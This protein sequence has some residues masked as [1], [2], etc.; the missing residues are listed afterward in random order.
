[1]KK[2][3]LATFILATCASSGAFAQCNGNVYAMNAGRGHVGFLIDLQ[4][5]KKLTGAYDGSR[6]LKESRTLFS[7]SAMAYDA[8]NNRIYYV[9]APRP[10]AYHVQG[11]EDDTNSGEFP[12]LDFHASKLKK[13]QLAYY[14]PDTGTHSIVGDTPD[15]FRMAFDP[16]TNTLY[17]SDNSDIFTINTS[18][19]STAKIG[20]FPSGMRSGGY[21]SWGDF[22][23]YQGKLL[24]VT[25]TRTFTINTSTG[26]TKLESF[27]F[28][29]FVTAA[30]LDQNGQMLVAAKNQ[31]VTGNINSTRLWRL[32]PDTGEKV[33][34]GLFPNRISALTTNTLE[35]YKCYDGTVF[36]SE[37]VIE[38]TGVSGDTV[39]EGQNAT[40][41]VN[42]DKE[43]KASKEVTLALRDGT[44]I[45]G[46]DYQTGVT[47]RFGDE[48]TS[49]T[50]TSAGVK[51]DIPP[52][53][54]SISV[55][56]PT[57]DDDDDEEA[58]TF[59]LDAWIKDDQGDKAWGTVTINDNDEPLGACSSG[60]KL[61]MSAGGDGAWSY[62]GVDCDKSDVYFN[63]AGLYH[64]SARHTRLRWT[65][66]YGSFSTTSYDRYS[67]G[68]RG[69]VGVTEVKTLKTLSISG[70][71]TIK[72]ACQHGDVRGTP[73]SYVYNG[74]I[75]IKEDGSQQCFLQLN[76]DFCDGADNRVRKVATS[77]SCN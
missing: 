3:T 44:A 66:D 30:T 18:D 24:L 51:V 37:T 72:P 9:S 34:V 5:D 14:D 8:V 23:F 64:S 75:T 7:S 43:L 19:A 13:N 63:A 55:I 76:Y 70:S 33:S 54:S 52:G 31:N 29:N 71:S 60:V 20:E 21:S 69:Y 22:V 1:M 58:K 17:A 32:N 57:I 50:L 38:V 49:A 11:L 73:L 28:V 25:N 48:S 4:E 39:T 10:E 26:E 74:T 45:A 56:V 36:P 16:T 42:F 65:T 53:V 15:V 27:H 62:F 12:S 59:S 77:Y 2:H 67:G 47:V 68:I 41:T 40:F 61:Q 35:A 46:T 6:A